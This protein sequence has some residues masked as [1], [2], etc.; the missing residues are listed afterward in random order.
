[1]CI[2]Y[3]MEGLQFY[4]K[5]IINFYFKNLKKKNTLKETR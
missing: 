3:K 5:I 1:M 2:S 4:I